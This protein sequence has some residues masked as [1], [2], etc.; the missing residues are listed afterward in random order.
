MSP[1]NCA[2]IGAWALVR[3]PRPKQLFPTG[4]KNLYELL[5]MDHEPVLID[6]F[7]EDEVQKSRDREPDTLTYNR[8]FDPMLYFWPVDGQHVV[9]YFDTFRPPELDRLVQAMQ[10]DGAAWVTAIYR[11]NK[12]FARFTSPEWTK[13][14]GFDTH[15]YESWGDADG[16][17]LKRYGPAVDPVA[18]SGGRGGPGLAGAEPG[19]PDH[20][21]EPHGQRQDG[22]GDGAPLAGA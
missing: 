16:F 15:V 1:S 18:V 19:A 10:R 8:N 13:A 9:V 11:K 12:T 7:P 3:E 17:M 14:D 4:G 6:V 20:R 5:R 21:S 22:D 2:T